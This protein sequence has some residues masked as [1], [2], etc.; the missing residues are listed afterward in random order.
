[1]IGQI[2][3]A[4]SRFRRAISRSE[5]MVRALR[6]SVCDRGAGPGLVLLQID[7]LARMELEKALAAREMPFLKRLLDREHYQLHD[8][9]PGVP[10]ST[11]PF[12]SELF[13]GARLGVPGFSFLDR[14]TARLVRMFEPGAASRAEQR[15][16]AEGGTPLLRDGSAY[17]DIFTGGAAEPHFCPAAQ[18]WGP[19]LRQ[20]S[21]FLVALF[22][23]SN[24][25]SLIRTLALLLLESAIALVD[26]ARGLVAGRSLLKELK[27]I[28]TRLAIVILLRELSTI[29][30]K[31]DVARGL[32]IIHMNLLGY[33]E[34]A[35][36]RGPT[37]RFAHWSLKGIDDS[38]A[39]VSR[40][41]ARSSRR[42]YDVW[43]YSDHGQET[44]VPYERAH[45]RAYDEA[46]AGVFAEHEGE[47]VRYI[48][49]G[50][51]GVALQR[52]R[53]VGGS[54]VQRLF[55]GQE[56]ELGA[57]AHVQL[58]IT[59]AGPL[60]FVY[61]A[62]ALAASERD[63][64]GRA[65]ATTAKLPLVL[66]RDK[67][68]RCRAWTASASLWLPD[69]RVEVLGPNHP[70]LEQ[71]SADLIELCHHQDA[72]DFVISGWRNGHSAI[73]FAMENGSHGG[74][75]PK[76]TRGFA[77]L[78]KDA[79]V[80]STGP[81]L[82][83]CDLRGGALR[84]L[85]RA[86]PSKRVTGT[87]EPPR[88]KLRIVTYNVH[89]CVGMD[90]KLSPERIARVIARCNADIVA[91]QELDVGRTRTGGIDQAHRIGHLL[92][93]A[94]HFHPAI[95]VE[96][97][98][99]GDAILSSLPLQLIKAGALPG[100]A[101]PD[102]GM[103]PRGALWVKVDAGKTQLN[104]INT[105]LGLL[106]NERR[107]QIA[108]LMGPEW[109]G[110][111][112]CHSPT[113]LCGDFNA[114]PRA[115][116]LRQLAGRLEDAQAALGQQRPRGTFA[117]RFAVARIDHVFVDP[118]IKVTDVEV[119]NTALN[120]VASDHLPLIVEFELPTLGAAVAPDAVQ[121]AG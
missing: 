49:G 118:A 50:R 64:I 44:T 109:L 13:Y 79:P 41:A 39:R 68:G 93:M 3:L 37:S 90:G 121:A 11:A 6:L 84:H 34:Q 97:E 108:A 26:F 7:G 38:I 53:L 5:W 61:Y 113:I 27:F 111:S 30:A 89:T 76:E 24:L 105:H 17:A 94:V 117:S 56:Q 106:P 40:A 81:Y 62:R 2:E 25:Y 102:P 70:F 29:G 60:S 88:R 86:P 48:S 36:R 42:H 112:A 23:L 85:G 14:K 103:E 75:G 92:E 80:I 63:R 52:A 4:F 10:A 77:L 47:P 96:E 98:Q 110:N 21:Q 99:Y 119:P 120:R 59:T 100:P 66:A 51:S 73:T 16:N 67:P 95:H 9:Y 78:P 57:A 15:L 45:G 1:M 74:F 32:P 116:A 69:D 18:G 87:T 46:V 8:H 101:Q 115:P 20:A 107:R 35:H 19:A 65:L 71:A 22:F 91:L 83:P 104:V 58:A 33:D 31:I 12:Q 72:G 55:S 28:P 54:R 82:R 114:L 43:V